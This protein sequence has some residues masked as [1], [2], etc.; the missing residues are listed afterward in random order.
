VTREARKAL[1]TLA[2]ELTFMALVAWYVL[3]YQLDNLVD[4]LRRLLAWLGIDPP[5]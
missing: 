1:W 3:T 2:L 4:L 5:G